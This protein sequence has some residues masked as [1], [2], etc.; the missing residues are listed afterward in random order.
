MMK[1][2]VK[3][4]FLTGIVYGTIAWGNNA[5]V[6]L[7]RGIQ[8]FEVKDY[9]RAKNFLEASIQENAQ[10][11][12]TYFWLGKTYQ[13]LDQD[14][15]AESAFVKALSLSSK[16]GALHASLGL[17]YHEQ[18]KLKLAKKHLAFA[19]KYRT[20]EPLVWLKL[21]DIY[22]REKKYKQALNAYQKA[23][24]DDSQNQDARVGEVK[25][26]LSMGKTPG[27][28][29]FMLESLKADF[30]RNMLARHLLSQ[31][32][33]EKNNPDQAIRELSDT[34]RISP[35]NH[36]TWFALGQT[37]SQT[38]R[39]TQALKAFDRSLKYGAA[40]HDVY[41]E[42]GKIYVV[43]N[44]PQRALKDLQKCT[45]LKDNHSD[46]WLYQGK[47]HTALKAFPQAVEAF[48]H[49]L[50]FDKSKRDIA[51]A[52]LGDVYLAQNNFNLAKT[53]Y[54]RALKVNKKSA[55]AL[56]GLARVNEEQGNLKAAMSAY[57]K[58]AKKKTATSMKSRERL[59]YIYLKQKKHKTAFNYFKKA[60]SDNPNS[61]TLWNAYGESAFG[62]KDY[63][64]ALDAF[65]RSI[66]FY[67]P[68]H[69]P[70]ENKAKTFVAMGQYKNAEKA[71]RAAL[72]REPKR[73]ALLESYYEVGKAL[74]DEKIQVSSLQ[75]LQKVDAR[76]ARHPYRLAQYHQEKKNF[77]YAKRSYL[78][79][80]KRQPSH[81]P[82][83]L[84]LGDLT[85]QANQFEESYVHYNKMLGMD[86]NNLI[87]LDRL[88]KIGLKQKRFQSSASMFSKYLRLKPK[89]K[90]Q[91]FL[92]AIAKDALKTPKK[93][94]LKDYERA[95]KLDPKNTKAGLKIAQLNEEMGNQKGAVEAY[96]TILAQTPD[97]KDALKN[98]GFLMMA[99][100]DYKQAIDDFEKLHAQTSPTEKTALAL[101]RAYMKKQ[102][103]KKAQQSFEFGLSLRSANNE[104]ILYELALAQEAQGN[105]QDAIDSLRKITLKNNQALKAQQKMGDL[106]LANQE[107]KKAIAMFKIVTSRQPGSAIHF[108]KL[109]HAYHQAN[110]KRN[111]LKAYQKAVLLKADLHESFYALGALEPKKALNHFETAAK[112]KPD[113][114]KYNLAYAQTLY[115]GQK[116]VKSLSFYKKADALDKK[117]TEVLS[118]LT[119]A[120]AKNKKHQ[121]SLEA[122]D[123]HIKLDPE[124]VK[125]YQ[126]K[127]LALMELKKYSE[128]AKVFDQAF[129]RKSQDV[130]LAY[131]RAQAYHKAG[132][133]KQAIKAYNDVLDIDAQHFQALS[134]QGEIYYH[135]GDKALALKQL[136]KASKLNEKDLQ[137]HEMLGD[138][139]FDKKDLRSSYEAYGV[140]I[141]NTKKNALAYLRMGI[142]A[143]R[144]DEHQDAKQYLQSTIQLDAKQPLAHYELGQVYTKTK[145]NGPALTSFEK[146]T[147]LKS[148]YAQAWYAKAELFD[149]QKQKKRKQEAYKKAISIDPEYIEARLALAGLHEKYNAYTNAL[150]QYRMIMGIDSQRKD[151]LM[152]LGELNLMLDQ[153]QQATKDMAK[154]V[155][156][157]PKD[158]DVQLL[159]G[160][161]FYLSNE[162]R[163]ARKILSQVIL[164]DRNQSRAHTYLGLIYEK[165][166]KP[167]RAKRAFENAIAINPKDALAY[168]GL[169]QRLVAEK[170][171][172]LAVTMEKKA[173]NLDPN[174]AE[175]YYQL[176]IAYKAMGMEKEADKA[177][178][179]SVKVGSIGNLN[180]KALQNAYENYNK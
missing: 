103:Y 174:I 166:D 35:K 51:Y 55:Q 158:V 141:V 180:D 38:N 34:L 119:Q 133:S 15:M 154:F 11:D 126:G 53:S 17:L 59:G 63:I 118:G 134:H 74:K 159:Y 10:N 105:Y 50:H 152:K 156:K 24:R 28:M 22:T 67:T 130:T 122:Y 129:K 29:V 111:A 14:G 170:N 139:Y 69:K 143:S 107:P 43:N 131:Q 76:N 77:E 39:H 97:S 157:F 62:L 57:K 144:W 145:E 8:S 1:E 81:K 150:K 148:N 167:E 160:K 165:E 113:E 91:S 72:K 115:A 175:A 137:V 89:S 142:I 45:A 138:L 108:E 37:L 31:A 41:F 71:Y 49:V 153:P 168:H 112:L 93:E 99:M 82:T 44:K 151:V 114:L 32:Y 7:E 12:Q 6:N 104:P 2:V 178:S 66:A 33:L 90:E 176:G 140:V 27:N 132:M 9:L 26:H 92:Y 155:K 20:E 117:N 48:E 96:R 164:L 83:I 87:A 94:L 146:A 30:P 42:K 124:N 172:Q 54:Q 163:D 13:K 169:G 5:E 79:A 125:V 102:Q 36:G 110:Q 68:L 40:K 73:I 161:A 84:A 101:G 80:L 75:K 85:Y 162:L 88:G 179:Q 100:K 171:Y 127:A 70:Y 149:D 23:I 128:S 65:D 3:I 78:E 60:T 136:E 16:S 21:G 58:G 173:I 19:G 4:I 123:R 52:L 98:K 86:D 116:Y 109:G 46:C 106:Y 18:N 135:Q 25:T 120:L 177:F 47:A 121:A 95:F 147:Q 56:F 61:A 64:V